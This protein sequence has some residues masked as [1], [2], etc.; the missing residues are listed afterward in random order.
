[1]LDFRHASSIISIIYRVFM[2]FFAIGIIIL[3][4]ALNFITILKA[5]IRVNLQQSLMIHLFHFTFL[6]YFN[7]Q[8]KATKIPAVNMI[9]TRYQLIVSSNK[10]RCCN[11]GITFSKQIQCWIWLV[12]LSLCS[13]PPDVAA[14]SILLLESNPWLCSGQFSPD[15]QF[16]QLVIQIAH[17]KHYLVID[18]LGWPQP[19]A[20][21]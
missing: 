15:L 4:S 6:I 5:F 19:C 10:F 9:A 11:W 13:V 16:R 7:L 14:A 8:K 1:M 2:A 3:N 17:T 18:V 12:K 20:L 21:P